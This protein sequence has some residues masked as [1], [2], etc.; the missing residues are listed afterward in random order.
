MDNKPTVVVTNPINTDALSILRNF[1]Q[2]HQLN[3]P[4]EDELIDAV[5]PADALLN[6]D[7]A[8]KITERVLKAGK[9]LKIV[10]RHGVGYDNVDVTAATRLGIVVTN[11]PGSN[12]DAV[13][14]L[15]ITMIL[16]L[17]R[18]LVRAHCSVLK[19]EWNRQQLMGVGV[20][21]KT[22]GIVGLGNIGKRVVALSKSLG[23]RVIY[24]DPYQPSQPTFDAEAAASLDDLLS[25][26]DFISI[27]T[28]LTDETR[29]LIN[30]DRLRLMKRTAFLI[31]NARGSIVDENDLVEALREGW[32]AGAALDVF[33]NEPLSLGSPLRELDNVILTPHISGTTDHAHWQTAMIAVGEIQTVLSGQ[34]PRYALNPEVLGQYR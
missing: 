22:L 17:A 21:G 3:A 11:T 33:S 30:R 8:T 31:N 18:N 5:I 15:A 20:V 13:A 12:T 16:A 6:K 2:I 28:A 9:R 7:A 1:A 34:H 32:I 23:M 24:F 19:G 26:A 10:A 27:H 29:G 14:E 25:R 4:S